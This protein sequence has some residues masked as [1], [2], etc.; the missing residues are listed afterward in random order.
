M[1][2][3]VC[4]TVAVALL[5][6][7]SNAHAGNR[8]FYHCDGQ[9]YYCVQPKVHTPNCYVVCSDSQTVRINGYP[10]IS[11]SK[12]EQIISSCGT[13]SP[14]SDPCKPLCP[15]SSKHCW[16]HLK[17]KCHC[18]VHGNPEPIDGTPGPI[19]TKCYSESFYIGIGEVEA[20]IPVPEICVLAKERYDFRPLTLKYDCKDAD[21]PELECD[22][23]N[24]KN[25]CCVVETCEVYQCVTNCEMECRLVKRTGTVLIAVRREKVHGKLV[26]D[27][28]IG[29]K[30]K[31]QFG[32]YPENAVVLKAKTEK[33]INDALKTNVTLSAIGGPTDLKSML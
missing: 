30:G 9:A 29:P 2:T 26:A 33:E 11:P 27:V 20:T 16:P 28:I 7:C 5:L 21:C 24:C 13:P 8:Y 22:F 4:S 31:M 18:K 15:P 3:R 6:W 1:V 14:T 23:K 32:A 19:E 12:A 25:D 17:H 10:T